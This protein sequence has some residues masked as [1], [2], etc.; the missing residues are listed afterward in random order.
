MEYLKEFPKLFGYAVRGDAL[1]V[2][3]GGGFALGFLTGV[4]SLGALASFV[5]SVVSLLVVGYVFGYLIDVVRIASRGED[6]PADMPDYKDPV[7][8]FLKPIG[9]FLFLF[10]LAYLPMFAGLGII[11][12]IGS[13]GGLLSLVV[14]L[15]GLAGFTA[16]PILLVRFAVSGSYKETLQLP[17]IYVSALKILPF[18]AFTVL[19]FLI[20]GALCALIGAA[21]QFGAALFPGTEGPISVGVTSIGAAIPFV[22]LSIGQCF[23]LGRMYFHFKDTLRWDS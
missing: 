4:G 20:L 13:I 10:L 16:L 23:L 6:Y 17:E 7:Q 9:A 18:Y 11:Q 19:F 3:V 22:F 5:A 15:L 14:G 12:V 8:S 21:I 1:K 2:A